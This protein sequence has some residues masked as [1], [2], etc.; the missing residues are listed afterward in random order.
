LV[1]PAGNLVKT[2]AKKREL[3]FFCHPIEQTWRDLA[4]QILAQRCLT[5]LLTSKSGI[6][7]VK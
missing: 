4:E 7:R 3:G 1:S 2:A 6:P 5:I